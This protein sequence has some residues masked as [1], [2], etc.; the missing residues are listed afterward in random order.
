MSDA[1]TRTPE[2]A[3]SVTDSSPAGHGRH[4]GPA[5]ESEDAQ[6]MAPGPGRRRRSPGDGPGE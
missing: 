4:R 2:H 5:D 3:D 1:A 6:P